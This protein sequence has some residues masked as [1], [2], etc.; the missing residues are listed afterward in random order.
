MAALK[1]GKIVRE[2]FKFPSCCV[3][4]VKQMSWESRSN[5]IIHI[6]SVIFKQMMIQYISYSIFYRCQCPSPEEP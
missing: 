3:C 6:H 5:V 2:A 1:N 4:V